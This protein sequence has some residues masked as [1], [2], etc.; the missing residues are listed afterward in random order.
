MKGNG[1]RNN[2]MIEMIMVLCGVQDQLLKYSTGSSGEL[3]HM[4]NVLYSGKGGR[5]SKGAV[6]CT[7]STTHLGFRHQFLSL[8]EFDRQ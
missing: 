2:K 3:L 6:I 8:L 5:A 7:K 4:H 1:D